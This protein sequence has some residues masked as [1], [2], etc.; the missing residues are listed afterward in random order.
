M[1]GLTQVIVA[2]DV[3]TRAEVE[4]LVQRTGDAVAWYKVGKQLFTQA[5][6]GIVDYLKSQGKQ[7]FLDL[8]FHDIP[9]TVG[10]AVRSALAIGADMVNVHGCGGRAMME[11][12]AKAR[13]P[14]SLVIAV[15]VLTSMDQAAFTEAGYAG[16]VA[17]Q[18]SRLA[19]LAQT[20]GLD[21]VVA[22]GQESELITAAC[23]PRFVQVIPGIRPAAASVDDQKRVM[24]PA[25]AARAGAHYI[26]VGRPITQAADPA[27]AARGIVAE[28][29]SVGK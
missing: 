7:V 21:G 9:N 2:L 3:D 27:E 13:K 29:A 5:G 19:R 10:Q 14:G 1:Q 26:V 28:L 6:P 4:A 16:T 12:A 23:G 24:T 22:S 17:E 11:A 20:A 8:K 25:A 18:V 15:T